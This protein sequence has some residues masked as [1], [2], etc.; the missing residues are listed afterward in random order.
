MKIK[1]K[2]KDLKK[3]V[4]ISE[5]ERKSHPMTPPIDLFAQHIPRISAFWKNQLISISIPKNEPP[6]DLIKTHRALFIKKGELGRWMT[7]FYQVLQEIENQDN[8]LYCSWIKKLEFFNNVFLK[9]A[10]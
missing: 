4:N 9:S 8:E 2:H 1:E 5:K 3:Q 7:L 10:F 6:F